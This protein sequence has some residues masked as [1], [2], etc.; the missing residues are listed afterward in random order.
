MNY[1]EI[2]EL[3]KCIIRA[4]TTFV[5][6]CTLQINTLANLVNSFP[7][8]FQYVRV[9]CPCFLYLQYPIIVKKKKLVNSYIKW[10]GS[11][12]KVQSIAKF[13]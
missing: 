2:T 6:D 3:H 7:R 8:S 13:L 5:N 10:Y 9:L 1:Y 12:G 4:L 11:T